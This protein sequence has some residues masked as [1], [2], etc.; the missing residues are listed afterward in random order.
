[1]R[2]VLWAIAVSAF[3]SGAA[4]ADVQLVEEVVNSG[5]GP[6][7]TGARKTVNRISIKGSRQRV[8]TRIE[9]DKAVVRQLR[10]QGQRLEEDTIL[11]LDSARVYAIDPVQ[12][13]Y[14]RAGLPAPKPAGR[15]PVG[16]PANQP[17][18]A[19]SPAGPD[20]T[21]DPNREISFR[22]RVLADTL[23]LQ[24]LLCKRV[25]AELRVRHY[26]PGTR[27]VARE[28]RYVYQAWMAQD[29]PGYT[30][31]KR[32]RDLQRQKTSYPSL[33]SGGLEQLQD[34]VTEGDRLTTE[35]ESLVGFPM[36]SQLRVLVRTK[37]GET[38]VVTLSRRVIS[39]EHVPL[40][41]SLFG[42]T[43]ALRPMEE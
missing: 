20:S 34:A 38:P 19:T 30:E 2:E 32:F 4:A 27:T 28:N 29:F 9:A 12:A 7:K 3:C 24:G 21:A 26:T 6:R 16:R 40:P 23:R 33:L 35:I 17:V 43:A 39:L 25:A 15:L 41:D 1:M 42:V 5:I 36:Q 22:S 8:E 10:A 11:Q 18:P 37:A 13:V 14:T 31:I